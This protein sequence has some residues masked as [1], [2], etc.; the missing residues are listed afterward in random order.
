LETVEVPL[1]TLP[2]EL[3]DSLFGDLR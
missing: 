1:D 2:D 3:R